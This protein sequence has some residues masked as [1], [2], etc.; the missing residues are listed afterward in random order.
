MLKEVTAALAEYPIEEMAQAICDGKI[1][2]VQMV[3]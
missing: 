3:F 2:H 1:P